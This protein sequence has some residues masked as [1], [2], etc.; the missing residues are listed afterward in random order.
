MERKI[1]LHLFYMGIVTALIGI[2]ITTVS[3]YHF[4]RLEMRETLKHE[5][6]LVAESYMDTY[7]PDEL[8]RFSD[9]DLR[10][11]L[12]DSGG[13]V[14]FESDADAERM[15]NHL[16]RPEIIAALEKGWE[17]TQGCPIR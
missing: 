2:L 15:T 6:R 11:T 14:L 4:F 9:D 13:K 10:I 7:S 16:D 8:S 12:I 17:Q 1:N 3:Y 5:C